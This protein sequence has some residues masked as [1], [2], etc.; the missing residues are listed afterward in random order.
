VTLWTAA[1]F[2]LENPTMCAD[3]RARVDSAQRAQLL[4]RRAVVAAP[5]QSAPLDTIDVAV[6]PGVTLRVDTFTVHGLESVPDGVEQSIVRRRGTLLPYSARLDKGYTSLLVVVADSASAAT[7]TF[8]V[9]GRMV[10]AAVAEPE[11]RDEM[12]PLFS[13]M[14]AELTSKNPLAAFVAVEC[15]IERVNRT[16]PAT[17]E[18][19]IKETE[20]RAVN[21]EKDRK[22]M[23]RLNDA[24]GGHVFSGCAKDR[25]MYPGT[26]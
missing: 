12:K 17:A 19:W 22:A 20:A 10:V 21:P 13:L 24:L 3:T 7:G 15:E 23:L 9:D 1:F 11:L 16:Y 18:R 5:G 14:R 26:P 6:G 4:A 25:T 8:V 2:L